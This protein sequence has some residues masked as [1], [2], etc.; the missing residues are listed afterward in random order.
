MMAATSLRLFDKHRIP[1]EALVEKHRQQTDLKLVYASWYAPD[2]DE[3]DLFLLEVFDGF[4]GNLVDPLKEFFEIANPDPSGFNLG[5]GR[6]LHLILTN[7]E[8]FRVAAEEDWPLLQEFRKARAA[9][10]SRR[11][12]LAQSQA[13]PEECL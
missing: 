6:N 11:L 13:D 8:E 3:G 7:P 5:T 2:R 10:N 12:F 1:M 4:G 9:G